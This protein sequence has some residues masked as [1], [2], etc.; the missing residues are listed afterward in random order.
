MF[1]DIVQGLLVYGFFWIFSFHNQNMPSQVVCGFIIPHHS[2]VSWISGRSLICCNFVFDWHFTKPLINLMLGSVKAV[3]AHS[4][5]QFKL[6]L[7]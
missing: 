7:V 2:A 1:D 5:A 3:S 6:L 4:E